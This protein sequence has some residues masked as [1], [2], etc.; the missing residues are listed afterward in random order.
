M[1]DRVG[2]GVDLLGAGRVTVGRGDDGTVAVADGTPALVGV[3]G[4]SEVW[5]AVETDSEFGE[6]VRGDGAEPVEPPAQALRAAQRNSAGAVARTR[7][8]TRQGERTRS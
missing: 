8:P 2:G 1:V 3:P 6:A 5:T 4:G 7:V